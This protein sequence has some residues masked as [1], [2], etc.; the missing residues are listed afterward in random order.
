M[1]DLQYYLY[2]DD[3]FVH[4]FKKNVIP[5]LELIE[6]KLIDVVGIYCCEA[7]HVVGNIRNIS[8]FLEGEYVNS[9]WG[10]IQCKKVYLGDWNERS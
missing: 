10:S 3:N 5:D 4:R 6:E 8:S 7:S 2:Y 1:K 9:A